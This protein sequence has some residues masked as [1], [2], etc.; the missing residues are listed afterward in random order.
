M[1]RLFISLIFVFFGGIL[2]AQDY[3]VDF[4]V[5]D[6]G[7]FIR[8][9]SDKNYYVFE[10][11]S[12][13][14]EELKS[15]F[16]S[17]WQELKKMPPYFDY[18][19]RDSYFDKYK[20]I[21]NGLTP[22]YNLAFG[23]MKFDYSF[24]LQFRDGRMRV[25][26]PTV[27]VLQGLNRYTIEQ[28]MK[29]KDGKY[30]F[31]LS[32][33]DVASLKK[34]MVT[35]LTNGI[36]NELLIYAG[37]PEPEWGEACE[38]QDLEHVYFNLGQDNKFSYPDGSKY[39]V[40]RMEGLTKEQ[41]QK[42]IVKFLNEQYNGEFYDKL[43]YL[44]DWIYENGV[45]F[46]GYQ[47]LGIHTGLLGGTQTCSFFYKCYIACEDNMVKV[48][49]PKINAVTIHYDKQKDSEYSNLGDFL[50]TTGLCKKDGTRNPKKEKDFS[51]I[52]LMFN[53]LIFL[54]LHYAAESLKAMNTPEEE[55]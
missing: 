1:K 46:S 5:K 25:D 45:Y 9:D 27:E 22:E 2:A 26:A 33:S 40:F 13:D 55:W 43:N 18:P 35:D 52:E 7:S 4:R 10:Y 44:E 54:P 14:S 21:I 17:K 51:Q 24:Q 42:T 12:I 50:Y 41:I 28:W 20:G 49:V 48:F 3:R 53:A 15:I 29:V 16:Y 32:S 37:L 19:F 38:L 34:Q 30:S 39:C 23:P 36:I 47:N 11:S 8:E 6:D 31:L